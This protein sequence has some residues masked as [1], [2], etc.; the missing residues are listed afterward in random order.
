MMTRGVITK[1]LEGEITRS[2]WVMYISLPSEG[3][4]QIRRG[5]LPVTKVRLFGAAD[6]CVEG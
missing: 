6:V 5:C 3:N 4:R 2:L 1:N